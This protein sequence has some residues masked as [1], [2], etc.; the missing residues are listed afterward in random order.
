[1]DKA[2]SHADQ[3][4]DFFMNGSEFLI[5]K[6]WKK[7]ADYLVSNG[8]KLSISTN[9]IRL[10]PTTIRYLIDNQV[11]RVLNIS[12]DGATKETVESIRVKVKF[13]ELVKNMTFL[14]RY[15]T[16]KNYD[17]NLGISFVLMKRNYHEFPQLVRLIQRIRG[18]YP[19]PR[20]H[21]YCQSLENYTFS[22]EYVDFVN[23]EHHSLAERTKLVE[24]FEETLKA[25]KSSGI[26]VVVFYSHNLEDFI[27][28]GCPFSPLPISK[29]TSIEV[30]PS[31]SKQQVNC[32]PMLEPQATIAPLE[33]VITVGSEEKFNVT[34]FPNLVVPE[35][36]RG[37]QVKLFASIVVGDNVYIATPN[38]PF[39]SVNCVLYTEALENIMKKQ[40]IRAFANST[41]GKWQNF[42][43]GLHDIDLSD[44]SGSVDI[45]YGYA[46]SPTLSPTTMFEF[47][48]AAYQVVFS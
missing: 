39:G 4:F 24:T 11:V 2:F 32:S 1:V 41:L 29:S 23:R 33:H 40:G 28:Q 37:K 36:D 14:F 9:G 43:L 7:I 45:Y 6:G 19:L 42:N 30:A 22:E 8:V 16:E 25:S 46:N 3:I 38:G 13:D 35:N 10:I 20:V 44:F 26:S 27:K 47:V 48:G 15:A 17:F 18:D 31:K 21:V 34:F 12:I 5:Y